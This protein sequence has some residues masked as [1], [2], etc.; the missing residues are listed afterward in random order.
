MSEVTSVY[1]YQAVKASNEYGALCRR[2]IPKPWASAAPFGAMWCELGPGASSTAHSHED[3][4]IFIGWRGSAWLRVGHQ[5]VPLRE[6]D[7]V[8]VAAG[9]E[10]E[11]RNMSGEQPFV[12]L[13][14]YWVD[15]GGE[16]WS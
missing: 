16:V 8:H 5:E 14:C 1:P 7:M 15:A 13:S 2:L 12:C 4:E 3:D 6:G 10:H 9:E 11:L